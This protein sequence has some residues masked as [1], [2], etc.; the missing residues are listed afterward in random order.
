MNK[1][2]EIVLASLFIAAGLIIP[3]IFHTFHLGGPTFLPMHLPV[4]LA[5]MILPPSTALLVGVLTPVLSSL[6]TGMPLIYPILPIMVA[7]LGVYGFTIA[8]CRKN[9]ILIFSFLS[10]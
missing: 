8:I 4:L 7:E 1:T 3:M 10:S 2:K 5:G 9:I 6:F